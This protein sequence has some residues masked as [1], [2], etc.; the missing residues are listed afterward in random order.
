M[1]MAPQGKTASPV[2]PEQEGPGYT[3]VPCPRSR[4]LVQDAWWMSRRR[5][6]VHGLLEVDVTVARSILR[7]HREKTGEQV[8]FTAF[9]MVCVGAAVA[10]DRRLQ[11]YPDWRGRLVL[12]DDVDVLLGMEAGSEEAGVPHMLLARAVNRRSV[13]D[14]HRDIRAAQANPV[15]QTS[16]ALLR[17]AAVPAVLRHLVYRIVERMPHWRRRVAGTVGLTSV[18]MFGSS[19]GWAL[20]A[21]GHS[22]AFLVGGI[23]VKPGL[24]DGQ[25]APR[26]I[27]NVTISFDHDLV[28]G[29]PAARFARR[30]TDLMESGFGLDG[31]GDPAAEET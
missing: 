23:S 29:A 31:L 12:F 28:D 7:R 16:K 3:L 19:G 13:V 27:L 22:L 30:F 6:L 25:L 4:Q 9:T 26:E 24:V 5:H 20:G 8:S 21:P 2:L 17:F 18:G 10:A 1:Q 14:V 15:D 11:A